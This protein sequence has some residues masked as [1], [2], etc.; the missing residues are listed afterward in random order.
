MALPSVPRGRR[1]ADPGGAGEP[2]GIAAGRPESPALGHGLPGTGLEPAATR[3]GPCSGAV[4][5]AVCSVDALRELPL[6][7][8]PQNRMLRVTKRV[9][10]QPAARGPSVA[11]GFAV[12]VESFASVTL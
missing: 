12:F 6:R 2:A 11:E 7:A 1:P 8:A 9:R 10:P 3:A 5:T 4:D